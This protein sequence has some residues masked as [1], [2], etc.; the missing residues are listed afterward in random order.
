MFKYILLFFLVLIPWNTPAAQNK[1]NFLLILCDD[2]G[3]QEWTNSHPIL[4]EIKANGGGWSVFV[5]LTD[6]WHVKAVRIEGKPDMFDILE[7]KN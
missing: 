4:D 6:G 2:C 7:D 5:K 3:M 1:P